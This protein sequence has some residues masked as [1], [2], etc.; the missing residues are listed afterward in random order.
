M[1]M[2]SSILT[3]LLS[4]SSA[5]PSVYGDSIDLCDFSMVFSDEFD[6]LSVSSWE[7]KDKRWMAHT[8]WRGD[9]GEAEFSD[10]GPDGP[11]S[12][13]DGILRITAKRDTTGRWRGWWSRVRGSAGSPSWDS[14]TRPHDRWWSANCLS[15]AVCP[16]AVYRTGLMLT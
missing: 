10:P 15:T 4:S 16:V 2:L 9:F 8:P 5:P 13:V 12:L 11:F 7:L 14:R 6:D 1:K 3:L